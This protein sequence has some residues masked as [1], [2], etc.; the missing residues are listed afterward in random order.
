MSSEAEARF[1]QAPLVP[2]AAAATLG[3]LAD[4][5]LELAVGF[6]LAVAALALLAGLAMRLAGRQGLGLL[7]LGL[8]C[9]ALGAA[10]HHTYCHL[11][12]GDD[13]GHFAGP[14][15]RPVVV[16]GQ[17]EEEPAPGPLPRPEP[18]RSI[19]RRRTTTALLRVAALRQR[20]GWVP[21][22][23][24]A[25]LIVAGDLPWAHLGA[26]VEVVGRLLAPRSPSN[27]G[28]ND[29]Q[30]Y[31]RD[32]RVRA[33]LWVRDEG[34]SIRQRA[35]GPALAPL[36][37]LARLRGWGHQLLVHW[38]PAS[39]HGLALAL[40]LGE[41]QLLPQTDWDKY[42]RTGVIHVLAVSGQHLSLLALFLWP[43]LRWGRVPRRAAAV[44]VAGV[45][46]S[47]AL[48]TG[49][50]PPALR[51]A[52]MAAALCGSLLCRR[53]PHGPTIFALAWLVVGLMQ[54][55]DWFDP[56]CQL[57]F[58]SVAVLWWGLPFRLPQAADPLDRLRAQLR[59]TWEQG[60]RSLAGRLLAA[61][62][63]T[64]AV[65]LALAPLLAADYHLVSPVALLLGPP[66]A[67]LAGLALGMGFL[68][69]ALAAGC[70]LL[71]P[72]PA[73]A[74]RLSLAGCELLVELGERLPAAYWYVP[75]LPKW[76]VAGFYLA[77]GAGLT[78]PAVRRR[79]RLVLLALVVWLST[80]L[81]LIA[82]GRSPPQGLRC[83]FLAV[84]HG[85]CTVL[86]TA[87][88]RVLLY[89]AGALGGPELTRRFI[90]PYLWHRG[91]VHIDEVFLSHAD[92]DHYNG[93][94]ELAEYFTIG[95]VRVTPT[96]AAREVEAVRLT[97][98]TLA[99]RGIPVRQVQAGDRFRAAALQLDVLHPPAGF[100]GENENARSLVLLVRH[101]GHTILLTGD[102]D[103]AGRQRLLSL[104]PLTVD[105]LQAPHHGS[106]LANPPELI[107]WATPRLAIACQGAPR[108][109]AREPDP[110]QLRG[111]RLLSTWTHG[112]ITLESSSQGLWVSTF[113]TAERWLL[114]PP[115]ED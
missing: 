105:V 39:Q 75:D 20:Q 54:P 113:R 101:A 111:I 33:L 69:L 109:P 85:G 72:L 52:V 97:L 51:A 102:L 83:T 92:L 19:P 22:R 35:E 16:W 37:W 7:Y 59:P 89:D 84:G 73:L 106:R 25:R 55:T 48:L 98:A 86:E 115:A 4:R 96:F 13:L 15:P 30:A 43:L 82:A 108:G 9:A 6:S 80:G 50:R 41:D 36:G 31:W 110:Y 10:Y 29:S 65:W 87:D 100:Q 14:E 11:Y 18:L 62:A 34:E 71:A 74:V 3:V 95:Q 2:V 99:Q 26:E 38:L 57:S 67:G 93:L 28:E 81:L 64:L 63:L 90:A 104:P 91:H 27:P 45:L 53:P 94:V 70:P 66:V 61:Y 77:L 44:L 68:L 32:R 103:G 88:G 40:L 56:G 112:A 47:Y 8:S 76:W 23:G 49:G 79:G 12:A 107:Q 42:R 24:R 1:W 58:L 21:V 78:L 5:F 46:A 114:V 60:V 17:L